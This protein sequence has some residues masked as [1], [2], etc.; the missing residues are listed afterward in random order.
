MAGSIKRAAEMIVG[1]QKGLAAV[2]IAPKD[3]PKQIQQR[4]RDKMKDVN[5]N[6]GVIVLIDIPGGTPCNSS[7][8][9]LSDKVQIIT[10]FNMPLLLKILMVRKTENNLKELCE[11]A[12]TYG[13]EHISTWECWSTP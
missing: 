12:T 6:E 8:P 2:D 13:R 10:G 9:L 3:G 7:V 4:I 11:R 1:P 5:E